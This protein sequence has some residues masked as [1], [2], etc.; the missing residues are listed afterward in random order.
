MFPTGFADR[1]V[2][3]HTQAGDLVLDPFAGRGTA[4]FSAATQG[5]AGV[6]IEISPVGFVYA[7]AKLAAAEHDEVAHRVQ[8][9]GRVATA[10]RYVE[11][12]RA[13]P[14]FFHR[15]F[16]APVRRFL[17]AA[18]DRLGWRRSATGP[19]GRGPL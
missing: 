5:R 2:R 17:L 12:A 19:T 1:V 18:R 10:A 11:S 6:G 4:I 9:I 14:P 7:K 13:L 16:A 15:C 3:E 8:E